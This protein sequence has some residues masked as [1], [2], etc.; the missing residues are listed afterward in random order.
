MSV[1]LI[2]CFVCLDSAALLLLNEQQTS[3][4]GQQ[5]LMNKVSILWFQ[6]DL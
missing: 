2:S 1:L 6:D 5:Y 4:T 3:H